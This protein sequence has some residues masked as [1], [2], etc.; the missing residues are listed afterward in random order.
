MY[1]VKYVSVLKFFHVR[2]GMG[3]ETEDQLPKICQYI[4]MCNYI[5]RYSILYDIKITFSDIEIT[6]TQIKYI[7]YLCTQIF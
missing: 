7:H 2:H 5:L 1:Q 3:S 4:A 6:S